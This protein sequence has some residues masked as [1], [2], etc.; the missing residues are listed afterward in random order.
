MG[1]GPL[2]VPAGGECRAECS[3]ELEKPLD[4]EVLMVEASDEF[5]LPAGV[6]LQ[7][8]IVHSLEVDVNH[9][10][11]VMHNESV[12]DTV[13]PVGTVMGHLCSVD[14]GMPALKT[15]TESETERTSQEFDPRLIEFG[16][17]PIPE[18]WKDR[19]RQK[20]SERAS[21]FSLHEWDVGLAKGVEHNIRLSDSR[22]FRERISAS[23]YRRCMKALARPSGYY[24]RLSN[25][26]SE[27]KEW[28]C[29]DVHRLQNPE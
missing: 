9:F 15:K 22:P 28:E 29:Q 21:V 18:Q 16:D 20:L 19:L 2:T 25:S 24:R 27:E 26:H 23:R 11:V 6:L 1:P 17:S 5:S 14:P 10:T 13:I 3:V 7:P 12:R 8:M 4:N